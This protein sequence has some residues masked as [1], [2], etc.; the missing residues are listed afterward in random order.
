METYCDICDNKGET[1]F[2][3]LFP[4]GSEGTHLCHTCDMLV[5]TFIREEKGKVLKQ[6]MVER[7]Q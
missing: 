4:F 7:G 1:K 3:N 5:V 6:K 2:L